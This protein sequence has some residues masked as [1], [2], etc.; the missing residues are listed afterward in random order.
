MPSREPQDLGQ[1]RALIEQ[2]LKTAREQV[3]R[4]Q[5]TVAFYERWLAEFPGLH[6]V[7]AT[8]GR[9]VETASPLGVAFADSP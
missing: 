8:S 4:W 9:P 2:E 6:A 7:P 3:Q 5:T 1:R